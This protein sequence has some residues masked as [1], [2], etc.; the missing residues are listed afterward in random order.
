MKKVFDKNGKQ[1]TDRTHQVLVPEPNETD[2]HI[3]E[4]VGRVADILDNGNVIVEDMDS[5]FFEIEA[6]RL[7]IVE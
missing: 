5:D 6:N 7:E 1:I 3:F 4:F 2:I